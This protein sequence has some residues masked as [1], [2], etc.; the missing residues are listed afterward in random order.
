MPIH[1][2]TLVHKL[3]MK[4]THGVMMSHLCYVLRS[5][6]KKDVTRTCR[7]ILEVV[8]KLFMKIIHEKK[9]WPTCVMYVDM[10]VVCLEYMYCCNK[11]MQIHLGTLVHK[12]LMKI[13]HG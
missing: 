1:L 12:L 10:G 8:H 7:F 5:G 2:R 3:L 13:T 6:R 4:I 11:N 9:S